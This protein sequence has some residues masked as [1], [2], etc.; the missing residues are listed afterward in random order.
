MAY[1]EGIVVQVIG[2]VV[3]IDFQDG[4]LPK[5][6]NSIKIPRIDLEGKEQELI[7]EAQQHLGENRISSR[8]E[9]IRYRRTY[10]CSSWS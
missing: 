7:V 10:F 2:P 9:S 3:D 5:I 1:N 6:Y 8:Y 4:Y